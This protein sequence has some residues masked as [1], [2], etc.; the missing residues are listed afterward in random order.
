M[1]FSILGIV[2]HYIYFQLLLTFSVLKFISNK[3][4]PHLFFGDFGAVN[5]SSASLLQ[6]VETER[7]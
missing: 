4:A 2:Y 3:S 7:V 6:L 5:V 1:P